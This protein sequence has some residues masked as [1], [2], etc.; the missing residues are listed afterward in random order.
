[1]H[2]KCSQSTV[3]KK[4]Y[5]HIFKFIYDCQAVNISFG[6]F[7]KGCGK[8]DSPRKTLKSTDVQYLSNDEP[9]Q[10]RASGCPQ[11]HFRAKLQQ[12]GRTVWCRPFGTDYS[13]LAAP[14][15]E[16]PWPY[17]SHSVY[18]LQSNYILTNPT[19]QLQKVFISHEF[20]M[21][22]KANILY[23]TI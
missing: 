11:V 13:S 12:I 23:V 5:Q 8:S 10:P 16:T 15:G 6:S 1:M 17:P 9:P 2:V 22:T 14:Q 19:F 7:K 21:H 4:T 3:R 18:I 20:S